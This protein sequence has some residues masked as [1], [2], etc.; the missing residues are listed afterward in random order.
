MEFIIHDIICVNPLNPCHPRSISFNIFITGHF[1]IFI[2]F[3]RHSCMPYP[4]FINYHKED[5]LGF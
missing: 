3:D 5:R 2:L 1:L 4:A